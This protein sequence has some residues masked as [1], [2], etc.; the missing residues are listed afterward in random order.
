MLKAAESWSQI[1]ELVAGGDYILG[2]KKDGTVAAVGNGQIAVSDWK[3]IVQI[4]A[5]SNYSL[6]LTREGKVLIAGNPHFDGQLFQNNEPISFIAAG[7][8]CSVGIGKN[9]IVTAGNIRLPNDLN[10]RKN[11]IQLAVG[12]N[13]V[14]VLLQSGEALCTRADW[15]TSTWKNIKAIAIS[16]NHMVG[17]RKDGTVV[18]VGNNEYGQCDVEGWTDI[19]KLTA[20]GDYTIGMKSDGTLVATGDFFKEA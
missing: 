18:A 8:N 3:N 12:G 11:I 20:S 14:A 4:A 7:P 15:D 2:L 19:V 16:Y 17:L 13:S 1:I 9:T 5:S 6:G 10:L